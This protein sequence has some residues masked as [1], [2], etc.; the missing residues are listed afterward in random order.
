MNPIYITVIIVVVAVMIAVAL[1]V[2]DIGHQN[3][4]NNSNSTI[5]TPYG[6]GYNLGDCKKYEAM[7]SSTSDQLAC[8]EGKIDKLIEM[9]KEK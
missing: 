3:W 6:T 7:Q 9:V 1:A 5:T 2:F 8:I 4:I